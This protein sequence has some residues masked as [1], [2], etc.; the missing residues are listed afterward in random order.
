MA[1]SRRSEIFSAG[2]DVCREAIGLVERLGIRPLP[3]VVVDGKLASRCY[4][5][6]A[7]EAALRTAGVGGHVS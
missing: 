5:R 6:G 7:D 2:C 3:A 4:G 1:K